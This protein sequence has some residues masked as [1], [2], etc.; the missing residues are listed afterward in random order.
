[1]RLCE[2]GEGEDDWGYNEI[3]RKNG[4]LILSLF[5]T[6]ESHHRCP[7]WSPH[8]APLF[9]LR[10]SPTSSGLWS[11]SGNLLRST[12]TLLRRSS[13]TAVPLHGGR[14]VNRLM[15]GIW[16]WFITA[17]QISGS[18]RGCYIT[19]ASMSEVHCVLNWSLSA[20][21][22]VGAYS[23]GN[24]LISARKPICSTLS[25]LQCLLLSKY[26]FSNNLWL[27]VGLPTLL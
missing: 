20:C 4:R 16:C 5:F 9:R 23:S 1:M 21:L 24:N 8:T 19:L 6:F 11:V 26:I 2:K 17:N 22:C 3:R 25:R 10:F 18:C 12:A 14:I 27:S 7:H 13:I 15:R